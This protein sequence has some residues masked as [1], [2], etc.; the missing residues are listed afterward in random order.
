MAKAKQSVKQKKKKKW[1]PIIAPKIFGESV[2]GESYVDSSEALMGKYVTANLSTVTN[3]M[4]NQNINI[5]FRVTSVKEG[6]G[7]SEVVD[8]RLIQSFVK[9]LVRRGRTK[10]DD[11]FIARTKD[12]IRVRVKPLVITKN[13]CV[14]SIATK[15]RLTTRDFLKKKISEQ[16]F[17]QSVQDILAGKF[18]KELKPLLNKI[19]PIKSVDVRSFG[20]EG[21]RGEFQQ[22][23]EIDEP[24]ELDDSSASAETASPE[25]SD[26]EST[27]S[28]SESSGSEDE[29]VSDE[30]EAKASE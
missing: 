1:F 12:G 14:G 15:I 23:K 29:P 13:R 27:D 22:A 10:V 30:P 16:S 7:Y 11:S 2:I 24:E 28:D 5:R 17:V 6:K 26:L 20:R 19:Y 4:K 8:F 18:Q 21:L 9:R 3:D 25:T